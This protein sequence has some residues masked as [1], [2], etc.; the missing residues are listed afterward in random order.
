MTINAELSSR[1]QRRLFLGTKKQAE[2]ITSAVVLALEDI[3]ASRI[4]EPGYSL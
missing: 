3:L 4:N 1:V 2:L